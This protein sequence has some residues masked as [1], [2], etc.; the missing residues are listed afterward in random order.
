MVVNKR[1]RKGDEITR[2]ASIVSD[3]PCHQRF[4]EFL[5]LEEADVL[6]G[7]HSVSAEVLGH[8]FGCCKRESRSVGHHYV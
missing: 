4:R 2:V 3:S 1:K 6:L 5:G 7:N 8:G